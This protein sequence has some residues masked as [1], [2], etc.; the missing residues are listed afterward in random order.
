MTRSPILQITQKGF[1]GWLLALER[2]ASDGVL[3]VSVEG[4]ETRIAFREGEIV[5][6]L[7]GGPADLLGAVL[8]VQKVLTAD[9]LA[10]VV[11]ARV[12]GEAP[13]FGE[14]CVAMGLAARGQVEAALVAQLRRKVLRGFQTPDAECRFQVT[15]I[16]DDGEVPPLRVAP[17]VIDGVRQYFDPARVE[18]VLGP[19][20]GLYPKTQGDAAA[21]ATRFGLKPNEAQFVSTI[22][23]RRTADA[24]LAS[25]NLDALHA[26]QILCGLVLAEVIGLDERRAVNSSALR[27]AW[28]STVSVSRPAPAFRGGASRPLSQRAPA[29]QTPPGPATASPSTSRRTTSPQAPDSLARGGA[30]ALPSSAARATEAPPVSSR[31]AAPPGG[32]ARSV[33]TDAAA[34]RQQAVEAFESGRAAARDGRSGMA[35]QHFRRAAELRPDAKEYRLHLSWLELQDATDP[36][37]REALRGRLDTL[38]R[39]VVVENRNLAMAHFVKGQLNLAANDDVAALKCFRVARR[40]DPDDREFERHCRLLEKRLGPK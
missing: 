37:T 1:A 22:D 38:V 12:A 34:R 17:L 10:Q 26:S 31:A 28:T 35:L 6:A 30:D 40:I 8:Q 16:L 4:V 11:A 5:G 19:Y 3:T 21:V 24:I 25:A 20:R 13:R 15:G 33:P 32:E 23:G 2:S 39:S 7:G 29:A 27:A 36:A 14:Q 9:Q 18:A